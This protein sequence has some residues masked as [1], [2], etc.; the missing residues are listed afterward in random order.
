MIHGRREYRYLSKVWHE[1][2]GLFVLWILWLVGAAIATVSNLRSFPSGKLITTINRHTC[3]NINMSTSY[4]THATFSSS[5]PDNDDDK[6]AHMAEPAGVLL[7]IRGMPRADRDARVCVDGLDR[8][9]RAGGNY[10]V[11]RKC[12]CG[13]ARAGAWTLGEG[14]PSC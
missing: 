5:T 9:M 1:L 7:G 10:T 14:Q 13:V 2:L 3:I 12:E 8:V 4:I 11:V 6:I